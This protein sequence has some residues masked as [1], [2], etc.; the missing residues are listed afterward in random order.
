ML[1]MKKKKTTRNKIS[2][3]K[4]L[5]IISWS[6]ASIL[7]LIGFLG[8]GYYVGYVE[9]TKYTETPSQTVKEKSSQQKMTKETSHEEDLKPQIEKNDSTP[10]QQSI[11]EVKKQPI[12]M[13]VPNS[14]AKK[15]EEDIKD[16]L[17]SV[18]DE[19]QNRY[20]IKGASHE[21]E[22][23][24][25]LLNKPIKP[26]EEAPVKELTQAQKKEELGKKQEKNRKKEL[27]PVKTT[28][29]TIKQE[30][31]IV[32]K[33]S[34]KPKLAIIIDDVSFEKEVKEIKQLHLTLTMSF[35]PPSSVHPDSAALAAKESLYMVHLPLEAMN[36]TATEPMTLKVDDSQQ[37]ITKRVEDIVKL[38]P[39]VHYLNNHTGSKFTADKQAMERL[40]QA[41]KK[42]NIHF[43]DSRTIADTKVPEVMKENSERYVG[44]D[45]FLDHTMDVASVKKQI[46]EAVKVA[47]TRGYAIA[48]GHPHEHTL[49][50]LRESKDILSQVEL[51][52]I[53][54]I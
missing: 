42:Y 31:P 45:V 13:E 29:K 16:R 1:S 30:K 7:A 2:A 26:S 17:K 25:E 15:Q 51:V 4:T 43:V 44:R 5:K 12:N 53:N 23:N 39:R 20:A 34:G 27:H 50:A 46:I 40:I 21:Y 41:L 8:I 37:M 3:N 6:I 32:E 36:F 24:P 54:K 52:Q 35:L 49:Q 28:E 47:K 19:A 14:N 9:G 10:T 48:I 18:L 22:G 33:F 38:F 11:N